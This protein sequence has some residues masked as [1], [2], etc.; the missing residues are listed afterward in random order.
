MVAS[1]VMCRELCAGS[2]D[3]Q[4]AKNN[5]IYSH[6]TPLDR[7]LNHPSSL[8]NP[9]PPFPQRTYQHEGIHSSKLAQPLH[10]ELIPPY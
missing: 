3:I 7:L 10:S 1:T 4:P 8:S 2:R 9:R 5:H 6:P